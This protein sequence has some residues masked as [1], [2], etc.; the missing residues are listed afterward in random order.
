M[1]KENE[2][3]YLKDERQL[4]GLPMLGFGSEGVVYRLNEKTALKLF[5]FDFDNYERDKE[6]FEYFQQ[7]NLK[8]FSFP[9]KLIFVGDRFSGYTMPLFEGKDLDRKPYKRNFS[10]MKKAI[11]KNEEHAKT[12]ADYKIKFFDMHTAN[13]LFK[14]N[15]KFIDVDSYLHNPSFSYHEC[16]EENLKQLNSLYMVIVR[17]GLNVDNLKRVKFIRPYEEELRNGNIN[18]VEYLERLQNALRERSDVEDITTFS[19]GSKVLRKLKY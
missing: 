9:E 4:S 6:K 8:D 19:Q 7:L 15:F 1:Q 16:V 13:V 5:S 3:I 12:L 14:G 2:Y 17:S 11:I 18:A 10:T